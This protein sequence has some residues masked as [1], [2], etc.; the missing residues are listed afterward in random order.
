MSESSNIISIKNIAEA[1][2]VSL[3]TVS[4]AFREKA[5]ITPQAYRSGQLRL[6]RTQYCRQ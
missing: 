3:M 5:G 1:C 6:R 4:R 2:G